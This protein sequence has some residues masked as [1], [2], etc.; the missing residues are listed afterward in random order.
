MDNKIFGISITEWLAI[1]GAFAWLPSIIDWINNWLTRPRLSMIPDRLVEIGYTANGHIVNVRL[2]F[3]T[4]KKEAL[5]RN[6]TLSL[7]HEKYDTHLFQWEWFEEEL[8][9]METLDAGSIPYKKNQR[10]IAIKV[11]EDNLIEKKVGFHETEFKKS[12]DK[13]IKELRDVFHIWMTQNK[14]MDD[15]RATNEYN[16]FQDLIKNSFSWRVGVYTAT[17]KVFTDDLKNAATEITIQFSLTSLD[18]KRLERNIAE[19]QEYTDNS[20]IV[21]NPDYKPNWNWIYTEVHE[22]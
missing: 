3:T 5:I 14:K 4:E 2:A 1:I 21:L 15:L 9:Q 17:V 8:M 18:L 16:A 10:A 7:K 11:L 22:I 13:K 19:T 20:F 6:V 12:Y